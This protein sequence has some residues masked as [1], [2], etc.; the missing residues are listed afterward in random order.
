MEKVYRVLTP[1]SIKM[2]GFYLIL[3]FLALC[4]VWIL[5]NLEHF[6]A[7]VQDLSI[8]FPFLFDV[9]QTFPWMVL[10]GTTLPK[11]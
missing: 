11:S 2:W 4:S 7:S 9:W 3:L 1:Y 5:N 8:L 6:S 10:V